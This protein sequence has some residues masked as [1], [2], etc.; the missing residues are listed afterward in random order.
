M[1]KV[2]LTLS[3][4]FGTVAYSKSTC[5]APDVH[6]MNPG[7]VIVAVLDSGLNLQDERFKSLLCK[8]GHRDF[9]GYGIS[10]YNGH[11]THVT[12]LIKRYAGERG[13]C[14]VIVKYYQNENEKDSYEKAFKYSIALNADIVNM[15]LSGEDYI[16]AEYNG[17][18][19]HP[20]TKFIVAAGND[21]VNIDGLK[22]YPASYNL[23][24]MF[25]VG[26]LL[27]NGYPNDHS[28]YGNTVKY[29]E[30]GTDVW[31]DSI[32]GNIIKKSGSSMATAVKTGKVVKGLV[33][34]NRITFR[35]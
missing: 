22:R 11:G 1:L 12:G 20:K 25:V 19:N 9:S 8:S 24:N 5:K 2:I 27:I 30:E 18:K 35:D 3:L 31:S 13:Y 29:W 34:E 14:L 17:I 4:V 33:N 32:D 26:N 7:K 16:K 28:N 23:P 15:S 10:D 21:G 6:K